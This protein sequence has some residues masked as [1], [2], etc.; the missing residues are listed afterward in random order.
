M[1]TDRK[2]FT[3]YLHPDN[4]ADTRALEAIDTV[5]KNNRG[6]LF[7]NVFMAGLALHRLD[8]RLPVMVAELSAGELTADKLV[9]LTALLT[10]WQP[11]KADIKS[12]LENLGG[13]VTAAP[14]KVKEPEQ[15]ESKKEA[16]KQAKRKLAGLL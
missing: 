14:L 3:L 8:R 11:S 2:K 4:E 1:S 9:E 7:R 5:P 15:S 16:L 13:A 10:G 12:V 6:E